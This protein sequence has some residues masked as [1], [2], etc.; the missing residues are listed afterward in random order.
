MAWRKIYENGGMNGGEIT[1]NYDPKDGELTAKLRGTLQVSLIGKSNIYPVHVPV[2]DLPQHIL[3]DIPA[4]EQWRGVGVHVMNQA[5]I[6][7]L[8]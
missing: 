2:V 7:C 1:V 8:N 4:G 6:L 5:V 3:D